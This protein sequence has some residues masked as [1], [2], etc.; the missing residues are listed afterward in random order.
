MSKVSNATGFSFIKTEEQGFELLHKLVAVAQPDAVFAQ[1]VTVGEYTLINT[2]E[3]SAGLGF[4]GGS[5]G[6][7]CGCGNDCD[8]DCG[9]GCDC[10]SPAENENNAGNLPEAET[11]G[12]GGSGGGMGGGGGAMARPVAA[13][14]IGPTGVKIEPIVD[15]TKIVLAFLTTLGAMAVMVSRINR[16]R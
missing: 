8:C 9:S 16:G 10:D 6:C 13:I 14:V 2:A 4:G 12:G 3:V 1:P 7:T 11:S 15:V 5:G